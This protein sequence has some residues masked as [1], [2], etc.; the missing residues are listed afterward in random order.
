[1][2]CTKSVVKPRAFSRQKR[3]RGALNMAAAAATEEI[4]KEM[5]KETGSGAKI[6]GAT[7]QPFFTEFANSAKRR[8]ANG[9]DCDKANITSFT[10]LE[11]RS[12]FA[13]CCMY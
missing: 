3:Q 6:P 12:F 11:T 10:L 8:L 5:Q 13:I 1:M 2:F 7:R 4:F 9:A